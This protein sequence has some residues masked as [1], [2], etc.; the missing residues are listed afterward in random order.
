MNGIHARFAVMIKKRLMQEIVDWHL[1][2]VA[3]RKVLNRC[4]II[5]I[6]VIIIIIITVIMIWCYNNKLAA[7]QYSL[8]T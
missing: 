5:I 3:A 2:I 7:P 8:G 4:P 6:I 1:N